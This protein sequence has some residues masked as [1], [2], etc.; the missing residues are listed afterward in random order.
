MT[1]DDL[2][3]LHHE[4]FRLTHSIMD[5]KLDLKGNKWIRSPFWPPHI[6]CEIT[7]STARIHE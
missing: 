7:H 1:I 3:N 2:P 5:G 6:I 4:V